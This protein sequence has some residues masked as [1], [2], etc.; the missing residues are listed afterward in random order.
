MCC[1]CFS[2][3]ELDNA[4][5]WAQAETDVETIIGQAIAAVPVRKIRLNLENAKKQFV[6]MN[7]LVAR[8]NVLIRQVR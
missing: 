1:Q 2:V 3:D 8:R 5:N 4:D 7:Q 6:L